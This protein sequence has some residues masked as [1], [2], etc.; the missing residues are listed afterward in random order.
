VDNRTVA[1]EFAEKLGLDRPVVALAFVES[2]PEEI[3][4]FAGA[5]PSACSFWPKAES[6]VFYASAEQHYNCPIGAM[7]MGF[8][9][10]DDL[11]DNL[12]QLVEN[13][14]AQK[15]ID[16]D[17]PQAIPSVASKKSGIVYGPLAEFPL[18][19]DLLLMWL[20]PAQAMLYNEAAGSAKWSDRMTP[21]LFGRPTCAAL[22]AA[23][24]QSSPTMSLGCTGMR[25]FTGTPPDKLLAAVPA[26]EAEQFVAS[27]TD[28]KQANA[29][30][31]EFYTGHKA[32][33]A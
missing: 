30:M 10:P 4:A 13:M 26:A 25:V 12:M 23:L 29:V 11:K 32:S 18:D 5:V 24:Q 6:E 3:N 19:P 9:M 17:E 7:T 14:C 20:S 16:S 8:D 15:Y 28:T 22:P 33:F 31:E 1:S 27:L 2:P 21:N